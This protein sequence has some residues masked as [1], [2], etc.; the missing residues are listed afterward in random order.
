MQTCFYPLIGIAG[1][2]EIGEPVKE[3]AVAD[4]EGRQ[5]G[6]GFSTH[7]NMEDCLVA[8]AKTNWIDASMFTY[9]FRLMH[10]QK[11]KDAVSACVNTGIGLV[12]MKTQGGGPVKTDSEAELQ[13]AG[14]SSRIGASPTSRPSSRPC[15]RILTLPASAPRCPI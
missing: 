11:M 2:N 9:N 8:A 14:N 3:W 7:N 15:G 1:L 5:I 4:E 10:T 6:F 12:A 13:A